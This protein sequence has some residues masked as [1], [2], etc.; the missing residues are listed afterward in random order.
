M[1]GAGRVY[2]HVVDRGGNVVGRVRDLK[3]GD[4]AIGITIDARKIGE[5]GALFERAAALEPAAVARALTR[6][7]DQARTAMGR[8]LVKQ[9]GLKYGDVR[10]ALFVNNATAG[11]LVAAVVAKGSFVPLS[12]FDARQG[13]KGVSAAPWAKRRLFPHTFIPHKA[14]SSANLWG[15]NV[16]VRK[17]KGRFPLHKLYGPAIPRELPKDQSAAAFHATVPVVLAARLDHE[18]GR[19]LGR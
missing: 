4:V 3:G 7:A 18:L 12:K 10:A 6:A 5:L 19:I 16:Y 9:T 13:L 11:H 1:A 17:G 2:G 14:G 8:G 15:G